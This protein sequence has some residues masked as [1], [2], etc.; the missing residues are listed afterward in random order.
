[1]P[2]MLYVVGWGLMVLANMPIAFTLGV[3]AFLFLW[4]DGGPLISAPQRLIAGID[5]FPLLAVPAFIV[6][7]EVMNAGGIT[8]RIFGF[9]KACA[10]HITGGL[11]HVNVAANVIMSGMSGSAVA[12]AASIGTL[13]IRAMK[14]EGY[15]RRYAGALTAA[16]CI[17]G[18]LIPPS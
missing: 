14:D 2:R 12:D 3:C 15:E 9:A 10:G 4:I 16:A 11:G 1:R 13:I 18:P 5:S 7:G 8:S 17:I 6:A